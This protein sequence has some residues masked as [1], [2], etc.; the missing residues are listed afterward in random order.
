[1]YWVLYKP[2]TCQTVFHKR[3]NGKLV[4]LFVAE[5]MEVSTLQ[6]SLQEEK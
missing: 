1:M 3:P 2:I 4:N 6:E 5:T